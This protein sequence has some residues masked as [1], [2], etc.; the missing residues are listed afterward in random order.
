[1]VRIEEGKSRSK[2]EFPCEIR[3]HIIIGNYAFASD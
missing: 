2:T 3:E 1:M